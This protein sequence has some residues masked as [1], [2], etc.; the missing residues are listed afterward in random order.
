MPEPQFVTKEI[1]AKTLN[2][3]PRRVLELAN[4]GQIKRHETYNPQTKR[5]QTVLLA[6]DV[7]KLVEQRI[8]D[9]LPAV[10][11]SPQ[12]AAPSAPRPP[13]LAALSPHAAFWLTLEQAED[14]T[15]LPAKHLVE[16]IKAGELAVRDVGIRRGAHGCWRIKRSDLDAMSGRTIMVAGE[17][18]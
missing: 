17:E 13:Q 6:A 14:Y 7:Q 10:A 15:G 8:T 4:E 3:S 9:V 2:L 1:A 12:L 5:R 16:C 11:P 18:S